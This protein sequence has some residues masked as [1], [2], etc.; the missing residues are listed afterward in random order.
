MSPYS[1]ATVTEGF[2]YTLRSPLATG[3]DPVAITAG[4]FGNGH[5]DLA[6]ADQSTNSVSILLNNGRGNFVAQ[7]PDLAWSRPV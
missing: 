3:R 6:V 7:H 5:L 2:K 1:W 4:D